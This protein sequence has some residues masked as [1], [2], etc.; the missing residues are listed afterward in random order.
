MEEDQQLEQIPEEEVLPEEQEELP[1]PAQPKR[2]RPAG[3]VN[4]V[5]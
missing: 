2:G 5:R 1:Q 3:S 4:K